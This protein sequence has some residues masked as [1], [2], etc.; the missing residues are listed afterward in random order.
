V[1]G[2]LRTSSSSIP[3]HVLLQQQGPTE[4]ARKATNTRRRPGK[5]ASL[6]ILPAWGRPE[7]RVMQ[8]RREAERIQAP[9]R[10]RFA[11]AT[12]QRRKPSPEQ[13]QDIGRRNC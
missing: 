12:R 3:G 8:I 7:R 5:A 2:L 1:R 13:A 9:Q 6:E 10:T 11:G 4:Y